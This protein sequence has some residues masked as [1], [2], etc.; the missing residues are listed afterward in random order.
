MNLHGHQ[1][2]KDM[3]GLHFLYLSLLD[4]R[5]RGGEPSSLHNMC[6]VLKSEALNQKTVIALST[7]SWLQEV[8]FNW[9]QIRHLLIAVNF[10]TLANKGVRWGITEIEAEQV[11]V[12]QV[13]SSAEPKPTCLLSHN[14]K[15]FWNGLYREKARQDLKTYISNIAHFASTS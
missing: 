10:R 12:L 4:E 11:S 5:E 15:G 2:P 8:N 6:E 1:K 3:Y 13:I 9:T 7:Y 14:L